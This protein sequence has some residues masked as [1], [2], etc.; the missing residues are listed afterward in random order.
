MGVLC[1]ETKIEELVGIK[2]DEGAE[3]TSG[4]NHDGLL[5]EVAVGKLRCRCLQ[6]HVL[7]SEVTQVYAAISYAVC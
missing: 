1:G 3:G 6:E 2:C 7:N 4:T 5:M